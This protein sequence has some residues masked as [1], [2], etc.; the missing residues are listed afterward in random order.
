MP[1]GTKTRKKKGDESTLYRVEKA[2]DKIMMAQLANRK[3]GLTFGS[4]EVSKDIKYADKQPVFPWGPRHAPSSRRDILINFAISA[5]FGAWIISARSADW[6]P[7]QFL[8]FGFMWRIFDKLK[9][10][11]PAEPSFSTEEE[12]QERRN[13]SGKRLLRTLGL[14]FSC[15]AVASLA[16]TGFLNAIEFMGLYI[17]RTLINGQEL[18]VTVISSVLLFLVGSY[19]R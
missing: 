15:I 19:Y 13:K 2:Y 18:I 5:L 11:E 10:F 14:V 9:K 12:G 4:F 7:L 6:K 17:P 3:K 1:R 8:I 16:Y